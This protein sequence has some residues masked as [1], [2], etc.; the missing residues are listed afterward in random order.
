MKKYIVRDEEDS[1]L[2]AA[3]YLY[4]L[5]GV[6]DRETLFE[7]IDFSDAN[8]T[9]GDKLDINDVL[10][11]D[12][13]SDWFTFEGNE[14]IPN[15]HFI[16]TFGHPTKK[17]I[18]NNL[19]G[20]LLEFDSFEKLL[21]KNPPFDNSTDYDQSSADLSVHEDGLNFSTNNLGEL[22]FKLPDIQGIESKYRHVVD[23]RDIL[24]FFHD[25]IKYERN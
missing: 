24:Y 15:R 14:L 1:V 11:N 13:F 20:K 6:I 10:F 18:Q 8:F 23:T 7:L 2:L 16:I 5:T 21:C 25:G 17:L 22:T 12:K 19:V 3:N 4:Q 9:N